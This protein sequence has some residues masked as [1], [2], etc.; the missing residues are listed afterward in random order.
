MGS[1]VS[2]PMLFPLGKP[3]ASES[4]HPILARTSA[5]DF[6]CRGHGTPV[7]LD[8]G[9]P[10]DCPISHDV[11]RGLGCG[12]EGMRVLPSLSLSQSL[13]LSLLNTNALRNFAGI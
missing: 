11:T 7:G 1:S 9:R 3:G 5:A 2:Q 8:G 4:S 13:S 12:G 10:G 6:S